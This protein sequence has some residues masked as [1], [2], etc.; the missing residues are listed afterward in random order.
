VRAVAVYLAPGTAALVDPACTAQANVSRGYWLACLDPQLSRR[1]TAAATTLGW[2][3]KETGRQWCILAKLAAAAG[4]PAERLDRP[5]L[6][7]ARE[8]LA[9]AVTAHRGR[10]PNT[11]TT[12]LHGLS[13][14][15]AALGILDK[16]DRKRVPGRGQPGH[17]KALDQQVPVMTAT[18]RRYLAQPGISMRPGSV[19][20]A[21]T[22]LRHLAGYLTAH[23]PGVTTIA[24]IRRTR[25]EGFKTWMTARPGYRG[26]TGPARTTTGMRISHLRGFFD[27]ITG[28]AMRTPQP[29]VPLSPGT[30]RSATGRCPASP[31]TPTPPG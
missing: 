11:F 12:P 31:T 21:G 1:F 22:T 16:P 2:D 28:W 13:A 4:R 15:L 24:A 6:G 26:S 10:L 17:W 27:R 3:D 5:R 14:T 20:L 25:I 18:M 29:A 19:A 7:A 9:A 30:C 8:A 23:Y